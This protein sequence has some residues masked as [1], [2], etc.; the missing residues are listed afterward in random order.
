MRWLATI[1]IGA[2]LL[3]VSSHA[4]DMHGSAQYEGLSPKLVEQLRNQDVNLSGANI[5]IFEAAAAQG[6]KKQA[7]LDQFGLGGGGPSSFE[8]IYIK[9]ARWPA[10]HRFRVCFFDGDA[11][12]RKHVFD[13]FEEIV[14]QTSLRLDR[15]DRNCPDSKADIQIRFNTPGCFAYYGKTSLAVIKDNVNKETM[16]LCNLTGPWWPGADGTIRHE[17][18][19]ALG[20]AHEHQHPESPCKDEIDLDAFRNPPYYDKDPKENEKAIN[21]NIAMLTKSYTA[22]QL[23]MIPYDPASVMHYRLEAKFFKKGLQN[24][25]CQ[26]ANPNNV[27]STADWTFLKKMYPK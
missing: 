11:N 3:T 21:V 26:L 14:N 22:A 23:E 13:L 8:Q 6:N 9:D 10:G 7:I 17:I 4:H 1:A 15:T 25:K 27:L 16:A 20:A 12:A 24:P 19:H 2:G 5:K 18:M